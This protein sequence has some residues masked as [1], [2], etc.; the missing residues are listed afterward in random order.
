MQDSTS[1]QLLQ[2]PETSLDN[3]DVSFAPTEIPLA[4]AL[5]NCSDI[6]PPTSVPEKKKRKQDESMKMHGFVN[7]IVK[8]A[9][10]AQAR[11]KPT[12]NLLSHSFR[13]G[14][15]QHANGDPSLSAQWIVDQG[16][17]YKQGIC[18][19]IQYGD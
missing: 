12:E 16:S 15:A 14:G 13:R 6:I 1:S 3:D 11:A 19:C 5:M 4:E 8:S 9:S 10:E 2:H 18:L 17:C 7:R